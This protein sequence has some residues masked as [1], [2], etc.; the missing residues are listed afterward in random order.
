MVL[1]LRMVRTAAGVALIAACATVVALAQRPTIP[2]MIERFRPN[3]PSWPPRV[4][5]LA[6]VSF[7]ELVSGADVIAR[8]TLSLRDTYLS[9]DETELFTE[10]D[11]RILSTIATRTVKPGQQMILR[12]FGGD[13]IISGVDVRMSDANFPLLPSG[14]PLL[15]FLSYNSRIDRWEVFEGIGAFAVMKDDRLQHL[16]TPEMP[17]YRRFN[18]MPLSDAVSEIESLR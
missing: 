5:E 17:A 11:I 3:V 2:Q 7:E 4:R 6:L 9:N 18:G 8:A 10:Y 14:Q 15:L 16:M 12:Q 1:T 13:K